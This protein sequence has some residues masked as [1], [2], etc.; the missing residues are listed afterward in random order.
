MLVEVVAE[1]GTTGWGESYGLA[2]ANAAVVEH[3]YGPRLVGAD[4]LATEA[5]WQDLYALLRD[6][7]RKGLAVQALSGVDIALWD[8]KGRL[9]G[10]PVHRL[11]GGPI[12]QRVRA[13]ATGLYSRPE[14]DPAQYLAEE[15]AGYAAEGFAAVKLKVGFGVAADVRN[16]RA[17]REAVGPEVA[18]MVDAN[19]AYDTA[20]AVELGR[21]IADLDVGWFEEPVP[22]EDLRGY[23][24]VRRGQPI[25]VAGGECE[26]TRFGF[27]ELF[28]RRCVD[29]AQ[30][31]TCAAG[32]LSECKKIADMANA[33]GV[34]YVPH[35]W[36]TG[37]ALAASLQ[38][39][40]VLPHNPPCRFPLEPLLEFDRTEHPIRQAVLHRPVEHERGWVAVPTGPGLGVEVDREALARFRSA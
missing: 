7:G 30:P 28:L 6:H 19:H 34:R 1:D 3:Y 37:I 2:R 13:Y 9:L 16:A 33:F 22:P 26:F 27:R 10:R 8:L 5:I 23:E 32:G 17:V 4:P 15:A 40:A 18:L 11:M 24:E 20:S 25:P 39:L 36:G 14:G 38:L 31:D 29:V 21:R 35:V 12:R